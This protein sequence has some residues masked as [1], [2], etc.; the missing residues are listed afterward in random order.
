MEQERTKNDVW[1][2]EHFM[3]DVRFS[4][5]NESQINSM[6]QGQYFKSNSTQRKAV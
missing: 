3:G 2:Y 5:G 6:A 1:I 4:S